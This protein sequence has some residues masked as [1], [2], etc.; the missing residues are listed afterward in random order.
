MVTISQPGATDRP[1]LPGDVV[2]VVSDT[3]WVLHSSVPVVTNWPG[4]PDDQVTVRV[5]PSVDPS[6]RYDLLPYPRTA[7]RRSTPSPTR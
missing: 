6:R 3:G 1:V 7:V 2:D 5:V 4:V